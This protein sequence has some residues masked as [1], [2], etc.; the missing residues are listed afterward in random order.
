MRGITWWPGLTHLCLSAS[1]APGRL[2]QDVM[3]L[4]RRN[5]DYPGPAAAEAPP[6]TSVFNMTSGKHSTWRLRVTAFVM[7]RKICSLPV[8]SG[9][10][11]AVPV[12][13]RGAGVGSCRG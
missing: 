5:I 8:A 1:R 10:A 2:A 9:N 13:W 3:N 12:G 11:G 4:L 6:V 7:L